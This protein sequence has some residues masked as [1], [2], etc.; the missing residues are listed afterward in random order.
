M[1]GHLDERGVDHGYV[2]GV[3]VGSFCALTL[4][5]IQV[6]GTESALSCESI[7]SRIFGGSGFVVCVSQNE[8]HGNGNDGIEVWV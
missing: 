2:R 3:R 6:S 8:R 1:E 4:E 7:R 5:R